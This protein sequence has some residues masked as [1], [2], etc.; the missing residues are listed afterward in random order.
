MS[1]D[2]EVIDGSVFFVSFV[3]FHLLR[4][5]LRFLHSIS[6][7]SSAGILPHVRCSM[8]HHYSL[9]LGYRRVLVATFSV[10]SFRFLG[11]EVS[12]DDVNAAW[13]EAVLLA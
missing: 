3:P 5:A 4:V 6:S 7:S 1:S 12:N 2:L 9:A 10:T 8:Y 13:R 11:L